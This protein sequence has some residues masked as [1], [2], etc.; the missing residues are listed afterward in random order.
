MFMLP[1]LCRYSELLPYEATSEL[2]N[3]EAEFLDYQL[4]EKREI[5]DDVWESAVATVDG[6][7]KYYRMDKIWELS[8]IH[9]S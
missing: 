2:D 9:K 8:T 6:S 7:Q 3:I 1:S 5:P 4:T